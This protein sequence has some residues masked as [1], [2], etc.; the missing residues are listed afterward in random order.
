MLLFV[1]IFR[2]IIYQMQPLVYTDAKF[3]N[4]KPKLFRFTLSGVKVNAFDF[5]DNCILPVAN[6]HESLGVNKY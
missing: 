2:A 1:D 3:T 6:R 5:F 4:H